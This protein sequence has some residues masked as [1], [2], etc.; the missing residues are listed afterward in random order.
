[1]FKRR[2]NLFFFI[3]EACLRVPLITTNRWFP[4]LISNGRCPTDRI[5][6]MSGCR[7]LMTL[8]AG[9]TDVKREMKE[10]AEGGGF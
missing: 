7:S 6:K 9:C 2:T 5:T 1:M 10:R 3:T 4:P 8:H